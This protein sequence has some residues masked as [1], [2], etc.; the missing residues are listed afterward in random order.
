M[1]YQ[2][3]AGEKIK[4]TRRSG[5]RKKGRRVRQ[6]PRQKRS[7]TPQRSA[8]GVGRLMTLALSQEAPQAASTPEPQQAKN[9]HKVGDSVSATLQVE[10]VADGRN[11]IPV[12]AGAMTAASG[13]A[14]PP[15]PPADASF[16]SVTSSKVKAARYK[17]RGAM[18]T[19]I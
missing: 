16:A 11:T 6:R 17:R 15:W 5:K 1:S 9:R 13:R 4:A 3:V 8:F 7:G 19:A 12:L 2:A 10:V 18:V 14:K